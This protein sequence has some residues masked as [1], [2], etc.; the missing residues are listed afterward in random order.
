ML[1]QE[2]EETNGNTEN[3]IMWLKVDFPIHF[4]AMYSKTFTFL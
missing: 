3:V 2:F 1:M 4:L